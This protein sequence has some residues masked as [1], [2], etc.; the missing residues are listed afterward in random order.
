VSRE[1]AIRSLAAPLQAFQQ[2]HTATL[3]Q[4]GHR[5]IDLSFPNP[6]ASSDDLPYQALADLAARL[7]SEDLRYSPFGGFTIPRRCVASTL[8][9]QHG[10][11]YT[12]RD[13]ILTPG[14]TAS[15][16]LALATMFT[17]PDRVVI[18]T[19]CWMDYPLYLASLGLDCDLV[20]SDDRKHLDLE[21]IGRRWTPFTRG[22]VLSQPASPTGVCYGPE[23]ITQLAHLLD[24]MRD[25]QGRPPLLINDET[26]RD[27]TWAGQQPQ[28]I[29]RAYTHTLSTYSYG[30]AWKMQGQ[31]IGYLAVH[32]GALDREAVRDRLALGMRITGFCAPNALS[33]QMLTTLSPY[34][35]DLGPL[36]D[37]QHH[38][39]SRLLRAGY[40]VVAAEATPF[41]YVR[42]P[43]ADD[44]Q[45]VRGAAAQGVLVMPSR[46]FHEPGY[47]R[48][49]LNTD[50]AA[51]DHAL[52]VMAQ[53]HDGQ[54]ARHA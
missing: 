52:D 39:R 1:A 5:A 45:F 6:P 46:L 31:R 37:L 10:V 13:V 7:T 49:A 40:D 28:S 36:A 4:F 16:S 2:L 51:L 33:Q 44:G 50:G 18:V 17:P 9:L 20:P 48:M 34:T 23:E 21:A 53:L 32:P 24:Q 3:R 19:P 14:A 35:P 27:E 25:A 47:F 8:T 15:V 12:Y 38:A 41:I 54:A 11:P 22:L 42:A 43:G 26:H 29:A 30:K